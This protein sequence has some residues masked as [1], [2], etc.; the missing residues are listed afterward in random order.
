MDGLRE[1]VK[2]ADRLDNI[3]YILLLNEHLVS[4]VNETDITEHRITHGLK[5]NKHWLLNVSEL[6]S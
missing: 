4:D 6:T 5:N 3:K 1:L 2:I